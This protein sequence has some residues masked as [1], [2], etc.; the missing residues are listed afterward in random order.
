MEIISIRRL[1]GAS[2]GSNIQAETCRVSVDLGTCYWKTIPDLE[3]HM[4]RR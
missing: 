3:K 4:Q 1:G 2:R